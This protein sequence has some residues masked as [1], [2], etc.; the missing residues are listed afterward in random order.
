MTS[1]SVGDVW[2]LQSRP[3]TAVEETRSFIGGG[4][5]L[6]AAVRAH[7]VGQG[8]LGGQLQM[9]LSIKDSSSS[10]LSLPDSQ[11]ASPR[12][13]DSGQW[14]ALEVDLSTGMAGGEPSL[15]DST[16][17]GGLVL[18]GPHA[19]EHRPGDRPVSPVGRPMSPS[20]VEVL[21]ALV[22]ARKSRHRVSTTPT[23]AAHSAAEEADDY[24]AG[25]HRNIESADALDRYRQTV[26]ARQNQPLVRALPRAAASCV[27]FRSTTGGYVEV[28]EAPPRV[29]S[30]CTTRRDGLLTPTR[31]PLRHFAV[32]LFVHT[33]H[34]Q[35]AG[36][37]PVARLKMGLPLH[38]RLACNRVHRRSA[39]PLT[40]MRAHRGGR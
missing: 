29:S 19:L 2:S 36:P 11:A 8:L 3:T 20:N 32:H 38:N 26:R 12:S 4:F 24:V 28:R 40:P 18:L 37:F 16:A 15:S 1:D 35:E 13:D 7:G 17:D 33:R 30:A 10:R 9:H 39:S 14:K 27:W 5:E 34:S 25:D 23:F 22:R 6:T 21:G 31:G